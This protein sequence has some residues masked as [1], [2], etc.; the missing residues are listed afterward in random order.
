MVLATLC[1]HRSRRLY[2]IHRK[3]PMYRCTTPGARVVALGGALSI[4]S[5]E[6]RLL[7]RIALELRKLRYATCVT[8]LVIESRRLI[9][10][11]AKVKPKRQDA[12]RVPGVVQTDSDI[13]AG[14]PVFRGTRVPVHLVADMIE[15]GALIEEILEGYPS[16]TREMVESAT[17]Y[18][19]AQPRSGQTPAQPWSG[20]KPVTRVKRRSPR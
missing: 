17:I 14:T 15:Q 8:Q 20:M 16:L 4:N 11:K 6:R 12:E 1:E 18:A 3:L 13:M 19:A 9:R 10:Q 2:R 5:R 7:A